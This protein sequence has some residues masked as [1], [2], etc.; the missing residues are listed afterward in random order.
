MNESIKEI[1]FSMEKLKEHRAEVAKQQSHSEN[2]ISVIPDGDDPTLPPR[3]HGEERPREA[4]E[5]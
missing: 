1:K 5:H 2:R 3:N 4:V